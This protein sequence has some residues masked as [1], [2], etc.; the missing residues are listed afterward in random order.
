MRDETPTRLARGSHVVPVAGTGWWLAAAFSAIAS[1]TFWLADLTGGILIVLGGV[2]L[3]GRVPVEVFAFAAVALGSLGVARRRWPGARRVVATGK[4][5]LTRLDKLLPATARKLLVLTALLLS[6]VVEGAHLLYSSNTTVLNPPAPRGCLVI[7]GENS[8]LRAGGGSL[9][10]SDGSWGLA[11]KVTT[12]ATIDGSQPFQAGD[13][14]LTWSG[15]LGALTEIERVVLPPEVLPGPED[16]S[17][18]SGPFYVLR[19]NCP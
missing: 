8:F 11:H 15:D 4:P 14:R 16:S 1:F 7:A 3:P 5:V 6:T 19:L 10:Q 18:E 2:V 12:F 13:Y 17:P 9:Y